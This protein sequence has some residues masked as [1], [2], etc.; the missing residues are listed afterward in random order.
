MTIKRA[1]PS[2]QPSQEAS[3]SQPATEALSPESSDAALATPSST[4]APSAQSST[5]ALPPRPFARPA[6]Q[7]LVEVPDD[8]PDP[9]ITSLAREV[10]RIFGNITAEAER[11]LRGDD[12]SPD[13]FFPEGPFAGP[14]VDKEEPEP[15]VT[16]PFKD[17]SSQTGQA[18]PP[19]R[20][21]I[22][23]M[24]KSKSDPDLTADV[25]K[26]DT[27]LGSDAPD[28]IALVRPINWR[29][30][31]HGPAFVAIWLE[32]TKKALGTED[33]EVMRAEDAGAIA[34][35]VEAAE[36]RMVAKYPAIDEGEVRVGRLW[37]EWVLRRD[38]VPPFC[39][40]D[41]ISAWEW[42]VYGDK[43]GAKKA[44]GL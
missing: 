15:F 11:P 23:W 5:Q 34:D 32:L 43:K 28:P 21:I 2:T 39:G 3:S 44:P 13:P 20:K 41:R 22:K 1:G 25:P 14:W 9:H 8:G 19:L 33:R 4:E 38:F 37:L 42:E 6:P 17:D 26:T 10:G 35:R 7:R 12:E 40:K 27:D 18:A 16:K 29:G 36:E 24:P 31:E 30:A